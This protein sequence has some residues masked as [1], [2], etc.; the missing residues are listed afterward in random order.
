MFNKDFVLMLLTKPFYLSLKSPKNLMHLFYLY[1]GKKLNI[2][3]HTQN[4]FLKN[5]MNAVVDGS[6]CWKQA[7][8]L[9]LPSN[10]Y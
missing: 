4:Q 5:I 8:K 2:M 7:K 9:F 3:V 10:W 1:L 6:F